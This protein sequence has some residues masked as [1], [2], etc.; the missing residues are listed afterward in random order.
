MVRSQVEGHSH[1]NS[2]AEVSRRGATYQMFLL[3]LDVKGV[4]RLSNL[5]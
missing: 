1:E 4:E 3:N 5:K 2:R